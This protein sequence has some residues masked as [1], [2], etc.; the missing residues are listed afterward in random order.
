MTYKNIETRISEG[1][2]TII[3]NRPQVLNALNRETM[4]ELSS[5]VEMAEASDAISGVILTGTGK[6]FMAGADIKELSALTPEEAKKLAITGQTL[7]SRIAS[8]SKPYVAAINGFA[9][10]AGCELAMACHIR[11]ASEEAKLGQPEV[12][13]GLIPGYGGTQRLAQ[14]IGKG[15]AFELLMTAATINAEEALKAGLINHLVSAS[16][17]LKKSE[18]MLREIFKNSPDAVRHV[19]AAVNAGY[20]FEKGGYESEADHFAQCFGS[21]A[22]NEGIA[23]FLEKRKAQFSKQ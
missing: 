10:G 14:L 15:K 20:E 22:F 11:I 17:L 4:D 23:A 9:L 2:L 13:L 3:F 6:A 8:A 18:D 1:I 5:A 7:F 12:K 19:I 16:E 21:A